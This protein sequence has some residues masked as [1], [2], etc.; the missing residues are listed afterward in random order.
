MRAVVGLML[1]VVGLTAQ[2][3][4]PEV[5]MLA[6]IRANV[7]EAVGHL[8]DC[9]CLETV[10]RLAR[11]AGRK[12]RPLDTVVLQILF[13]GGH[14]L[15]AS[16]GDTQWENNPS[17]FLSGGL[18]GNGLFA[19]Y[20][21]TVFLNNQS[22]IKY[23]AIEQS[24][25]RP[26]ARY[27]FTVSQMSSGFEIDNAGTG[28]VVGMS[29]WFWADPQSYDLQ[30]LEFHAVD[31]PPQLL[32]TDVS[33]SI[34]YN[35]V[36][37]GSS[38][39]LLPEDAEIRAVTGDAGYQDLVQFTHCHG[40]QTDSAV[41][42]DSGEIAPGSPR[43][44]APAASAAVQEPLPARV[45]ITAM[46]TTPIDDRAAVGSLVEGKVVGSVVYK[47]KVL[48]PDGAPIQGRLRRMQHWTVAGDYFVV[49]IE[50]TRIQTPGADFRFYAD[51]LDIDH[52]EGV[53]LTYST[54]ARSQTVEPLLNGT[55]MTNASIEQLWM[56]DI[57]GVG[58]FFIHGAH[59][60]LPAGFKTVW[61]TRQFPQSSQ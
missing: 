22:V 26:W 24:G 5:L 17:A 56:R 18:I 51:L 25:G 1:A 49:A 39:V 12:P 9:T 29:G 2:D 31:I 34:Q 7:A 27:D 58:T 14:E 13:S 54:T 33:L 43:A 28:A 11:P 3:L 40:F 10:A 41:R 45:R 60:S 53:E 19:L 23:H 15:F 44:A 8:P 35:R 20:L 6:R 59:F 48:V 38:D 46:L 61:L 57:P 37:V 30:R 4:P 42:F 21:R 52:R 50:F 55:V 47:G 32:Y 16:P 36:R